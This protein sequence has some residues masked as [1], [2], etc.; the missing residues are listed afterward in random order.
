M[1]LSLRSSDTAQ[2]ISQIGPNMKHR[3]SAYMENRV[4][5]TEIA[6]TFNYIL[7]D[8]FTKMGL[9]PVF[10]GQYQV[11]P[12]KPD[13][14]R[15]YSHHGSE[16]CS[17]LPISGGVIGRAIRTGEDQYVPDVTKDKEHIGCDPDM[18]G[19]ERVLISWSEP[20][21]AGANAGKQTAL[22]V[23]DL[24]FHTKDTLTLELQKELREVWD[25]Y[26]KLIFPGEAAFK[27]AIIAAYRA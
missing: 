2:S 6:T 10:V 12:A 16:A 15:V 9:N 11:D 27:P 14:T 4:Y 5:P 19:S 24:D 3:L 25:I 1:N 7:W 22:G 26:G 21:R 20:F 23:L 17:P 18:H 13:Q 8:E